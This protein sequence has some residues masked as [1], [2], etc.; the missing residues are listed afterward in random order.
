M[1]TL[2]ST[3]DGMTNDGHRPCLKAADRQAITTVASAIRVVHA[4]D[5]YSARILH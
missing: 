3:H 1:R 5:L 2:R 4:G